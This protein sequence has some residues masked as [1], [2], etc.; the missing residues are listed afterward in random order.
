MASNGF[1]VPLMAA[2]TPHSKNI[3]ARAITV[4]DVFLSLSRVV[5]STSH[6]D[7]PSLYELKISAAADINVMMRPNM[8]SMYNRRK[9]NVH[10]ANDVHSLLFF[11]I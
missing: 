3:R 6:V 5:K 2:K 1:T 4:T 9:E 8:D 11:S 7:A 10:V